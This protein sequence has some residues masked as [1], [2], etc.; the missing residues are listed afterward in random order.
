M[1]LSD[2]KSASGMFS[3]H[4]DDS[5][6]KD[7]AGNDL[8][9]DNKSA[10]KPPAPKKEVLDESYNNS[11][12]DD[13]SDYSQPIK[14]QPELPKPVEISRPNLAAKKDEKPRFDYLN[15]GKSESSEKYS[16]VEDEKNEGPEIDH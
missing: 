14:K 15:Y 1:N 12:N 10:S 4:Y 3:D 8:I 6:F 13:Y 11:L 5:F 16:E 2:D 7:G 9:S